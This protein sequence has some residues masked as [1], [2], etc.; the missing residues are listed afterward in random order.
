MFS[1]FHNNRFLRELKNLK[2]TNLK[3]HKTTMKI[4]FD[5]HEKVGKGSACVAMGL[6]CMVKWVEWE[7]IL[8]GHK[9]K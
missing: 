9:K 1:V 7:L 2:L 3:T 6:S 8:Y 4:P 5:Y